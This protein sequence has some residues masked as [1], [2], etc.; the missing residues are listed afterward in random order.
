LGSL[1][2]RCADACALPAGGALAVGREA[3]S[4]MVTE[5]IER[6]PLIHLARQEVTHLPDGTVVVAT[7]P[8]TSDRLAPE[9]VALA[10][11]E[12]LSFYDAMAPIVTLESVDQ[13]KVF[14]ASRWDRGAG[15]YI[16]CP[17]TA[18]E[19]EQFVEALLAA[20]TFPLRDFEQADP[21]FFESCLPVEVL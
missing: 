20:E 7:G 19:Y 5:A 8:L 2:M 21:R 13:S 3:F 18:A 14:R 17:M 15:D 16:N 4:Q 12:R 10:G 11:E 6:H 9:L 1:I